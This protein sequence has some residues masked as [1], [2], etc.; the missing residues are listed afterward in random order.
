MNRINV[1]LYHGPG[2]L[3]VNARGPE[4]GAS[5]RQKL[6]DLLE[7]AGPDDWVLVCGNMMRGLDADFL[8]G[9]CAKVHQRQARLV[10][11]MEALSPQLIQRCRPDLIKPN[12]YE[13]KLLTGQPD[14]TLGRTG[15]KRPRSCAKAASATHSCFVGGRGRSVGRL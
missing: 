8:T 2:T 4:A 5:V 15:R 10:I 11:D 9:L 12:F 7:A 3:C 13:F 6:L 1:K 14:L